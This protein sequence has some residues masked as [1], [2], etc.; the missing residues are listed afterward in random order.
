[1]SSKTIVI[2]GGSDGIGAAAARQLSAAGHQIVVVGRSPEKTKAVAAEIGAEFL[3][4]DFTKFTD[5][6][7]LA[8]ELL[9]RYPRI[10][11]LANNAGGIMGERAVTDDGHER[12][13]QINHLAPFL[14][15]SLLLDRLVESSATVINTSSVANRL[16]GRFDIADM[17]AETKYSPNLAYGNAK[18]ANI[19]FT[20]ELDRRFGTKG[21]STAAFHP[22]VVATGF[23][24][25]STSALRHVYQGVLSRFLLTPA[26]GADTLVW[27]A[28]GTPGTDWV[29]G[30]YYA[31]RK[32]AK[33]NPQATDTSL[34]SQLWD[35]SAEMVG[36]VPAE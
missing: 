4:A 23:S 27:L 12:T 1:V 21:I 15:T 17:D 28:S 3:L 25:G 29:R 16:Y 36:V 20:K 5:V 31:K 10:D 24:A 35:R 9:E 6:R 33:M 30:E 32:P 7:A 13:L 8:A 2:T 11:V 26:K 18:L 22:G 34:A 14:L 19:L